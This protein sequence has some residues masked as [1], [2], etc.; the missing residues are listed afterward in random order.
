M[1]NPYALYFDA[2]PCYLTVQGRGFRLIDA[3]RRF[4]EDFGDIE[5]RFCYQVYKRRSEKCEVCPVEDAF[6]DGQS[7]RGE[8]R[9][10][11]LDGKEVSVLVEATPIRDHSGKIVAVIEM[12]T[13]IT[14]IKSLEKQ[15]RRSRRRYH[16]LFDEVPATSRSRTPN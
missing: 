8:E 5:D 15:L 7:H 14:Q 16:L 1:E 9:V 6:R 3:N 2:M 13:D 12:S 4:R 10:R 11:C